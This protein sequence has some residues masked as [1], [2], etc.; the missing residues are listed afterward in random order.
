[1]NFSNFS[2]HRIFESE[3]FGFPF[4][5]E[6]S[7]T[8]GLNVKNKTSENRSGFLGKASKIVHEWNCYLDFLAVLKS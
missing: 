5:Y 7:L 1:M 2:L 8:W 6:N 4:Y 3:N